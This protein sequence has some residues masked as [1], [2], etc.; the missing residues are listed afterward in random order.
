MALACLLSF[1]LSAASS[2]VQGADSKGVGEWHVT[3]PLELFEWPEFGRPPGFPVVGVSDDG[4]VYV[5]A[6]ADDPGAGYQNVFLRTQPPGGTF[7]PPVKVSREGWYYPSSQPKIALSPDGAVLVA[8]RGI[9]GASSYRAKI[10][11]STDHGATFSKGVV[12]DADLDVHDLDLDFDPRGVLHVAMR[13]YTA[14]RNQD[15]FY[16]RTLHPVSP[17]GGGPFDGLDTSLF[18]VPV[19]L[20]RDKDIQTEPCLQA[21]PSNHIYLTYEVEGRRTESIFLTEGRMRRSVLLSS[22]RAQV[23]VGPS[24]LAGLIVTRFTGPLSGDTWLVRARDGAFYL[25]FVQVSPT[26][27]TI[28]FPGDARSIDVS[29]RDEIAVALTIAQFDVYPADLWIELNYSRD[30][31]E[32]WVPPVQLNR[33][34]RNPDGIRGISPSLAFGPDGRIHV[35]FLAA[36]DDPDWK[37]EE[38]VYVAAQYLIR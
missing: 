4:Y 14:R 38:I 30:A 18:T 28:D 10:A 27:A 15:I 20:T 12:V 23:S 5:A 37:R 16:S 36:M 19:N 13:G 2:I 17:A 3:P 29:P 26:D 24:G 7:G 6:W 33:Y 35:A 11:W 25:P 31:G 34:H 32:S 1:S 9:Q 21:D 22:A 8:W